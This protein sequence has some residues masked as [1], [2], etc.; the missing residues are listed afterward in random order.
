MKPNIV[1]MRLRLLVGVFSL[2]TVFASWSTAPSASAAPSPVSLSGFAANPVT[3]A[4]PGSMVLAQATVPT[5]L[6]PVPTAPPTAPT[7]LTAATATVHPTAPYVGPAS[8][9]YIPPGSE[10]IRD[11]RML[12]QGQL[13]HPRPQLYRNDPAAPTLSDSSLEGLITCP[14]M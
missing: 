9:S 12:M 2:L 13:S 1:A 7:P 8:S 11:P 4:A 5:V 14:M 6:P 3:P 10:A